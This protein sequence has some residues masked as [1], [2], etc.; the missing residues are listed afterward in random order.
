MVK[1]A[2]TK[3]KIVCPH[4]GHHKALRKVSKHNFGW[5]CGKCGKENKGTENYTNKHGVERVR[6][7]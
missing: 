7:I 1:R 2:I 6:A 4:C 5:F 3:S